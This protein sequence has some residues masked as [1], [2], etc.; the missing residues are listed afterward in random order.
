M[1]QK[2]EQKQ[3]SVN[4]AGLLVGKVLLLTLVWALFQAQ[5]EFAYLIVILLTFLAASTHI[6][7]Q[8]YS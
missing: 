3:V 8:K 1:S 5:M 4:V 6:T 7:N 2:R